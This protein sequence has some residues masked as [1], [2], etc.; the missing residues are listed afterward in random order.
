[1]DILIP[2]MSVIERSAAIKLAVIRFQEFR[3]TFSSSLGSE[4]QWLFLQFK[5]N[6]VRGQSN[7]KY[8]D[9]APLK[10]RRGQRT[11]L[12]LGWLE[13]IHLKC[14]VCILFQLSYSYN[15]PFFSCFL[16]IGTLFKVFNI[17]KLV[18]WG[19]LIFDSEYFNFVIQFCKPC[20]RES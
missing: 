16:F 2:M 20:H 6:F 5:G 3:Q 18:S 19:W 14:V 8:R 11:D 9:W 10:M 1:M 15:H 12:T 4:R 13:L 7:P 17:L